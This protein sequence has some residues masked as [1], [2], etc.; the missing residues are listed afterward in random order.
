MFSV[1]S[2]ATGRW[3]LWAALALS[4][5]AVLWGH[6]HPSRQ[7]AV[8]SNPAGATVY[9]NGHRLGVTPCSIQVGSRGMLRLEHPGYLP[10]EEFLRLDEP[11]GQQLHL[12]M[13]PGVAV[14][15]LRPAYPPSLG[16]PPAT[17]FQSRNHQLAG[18]AYAVPPGWRSEALPNRV[19]LSCGDGRSL[20]LRQASLVVIPGQL[21]EQWRQLQVEREQEGWTVVAS[22]IGLHSGWIRLERA[23]D[24]GL[25]R[26]ALLLQQEGDGLVELHYQYP[27][28]ADVFTYTRDLD[29]LRATLL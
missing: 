11:V 8:D 5:A 2:L 20:P 6:R 3:R 14:G 9:F 13:R 16:K 1:A 4:G 12:R 27:D 29:Y 21:A 24:L 7:L 23:N 10:A 26:S 22:Q 19:Q 28:C 25:S 17:R 18:H 15:P